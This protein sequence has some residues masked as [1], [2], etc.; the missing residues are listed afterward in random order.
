MPNKLIKLDK[1]KAEVERLQRYID[2]VED[3]ETDTLNKWIIK[4]YALSNSIKKILEEAN[5]TGVTND[6]G[7]PLDR[8][9]ITGVINGT[10]MDELHRILRLGYRRKIK[11]NKRKEHHRFW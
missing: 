9:Y 6:D 3:Y 5:E 1:A 2:L 10:V 4:Q 11:P 7:V 8:K